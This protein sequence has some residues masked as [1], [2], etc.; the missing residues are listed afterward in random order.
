MK[1]IEITGNI[2]DLLSF[3]KAEKKIY[4]RCPDCG[5]VFRLSDVKLTYGKQP[6]KDQLESLKR[7]R[8]RLFE[9][10]EKLQEEIEQVEEESREEI[11][12]LK[13]EHRGQIQ[14]LNEKWAE[15]VDTAV[16]RQLTKQIREVRKKAIA[17]SR[18]TM[19]GKTIERIA[20]MFSGFDHHPSDVRPIFEPIDFIIFS[21]LFSGEVT[22]LVFVEFKTAN[23]R[24]SDMQK[25]I[26]NTVQQKKVRF[27][28][29]RM[30]DRVLEALEKGHGLSGRKA[31]EVK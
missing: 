12:S 5:E 16:E 26:R 1:N 29:R 14:A 28:E 31:I 4:G 2:K 6:P 20:P 19:L 25:S 3:Y 30:N 15:K 8:E 24:L 13:Y 17:Q 23:G 10:L 7:Q 21:G 18:A 27:E 11:N 9:D 22:E